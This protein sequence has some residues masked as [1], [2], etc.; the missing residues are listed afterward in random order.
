ML[1][2]L[3]GA[4]FLNNLLK[5]NFWFFIDFYEKILKKH[6]FMTISSY[7]SKKVAPFLFRDFCLH[8]T[9]SKTNYYTL[10]PFPIIFG[11]L[12]YLKS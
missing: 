6:V 3:I 7:E 2:K 8:V 9:F 10:A 5:W 1:Q 11:V 12:K 4:I